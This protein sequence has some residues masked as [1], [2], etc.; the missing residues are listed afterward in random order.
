MM[1]DA[2]QIFQSVLEMRFVQLPGHRKV[3]RKEYALQ[4]NQ[5]KQEIDTALAFRRWFRPGQDIDMSM[6]FN[7]FATQNTSCPGCKLRRSGTCDSKVK[8]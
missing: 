4:A 7:S 3:Q 8:W 2:A 6:V 1:T 5:S